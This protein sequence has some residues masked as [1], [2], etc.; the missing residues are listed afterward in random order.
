VIIATHEGEYEQWDMPMT[1]LLAKAFSN[2]IRCIT[3]EGFF[4]S[5]R[6]RFFQGRNQ[7]EC[8]TEIL[9]ARG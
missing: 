8:A 6:M 7:Q 9:K 2:Q 1:T 4:E 5:R 3:W